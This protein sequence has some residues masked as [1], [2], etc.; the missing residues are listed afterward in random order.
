M[1]IDLPA[2]DNVASSSLLCW[3]VVVDVHVHQGHRDS[4]PDVNRSAAISVVDPAVK[5][6]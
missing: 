4:F 2:V 5:N 6:G 3:L 1:S